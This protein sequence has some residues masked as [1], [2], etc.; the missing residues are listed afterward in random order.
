MSQQLLALGV[1][2]VRLYDCVLTASATHPEDL[3]DAI[4]DEIN[5][6]LAHANRS[7]KA[8]LFHISCDLHEALSKRFDRV[9]GLAR[10]KAVLDLM[11]VL[12]SRARSIARLHGH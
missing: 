5:N 10:R 8:V 9:D 6:C 1:I 4:V 11:G 12:I 2:G 3:A 7:E